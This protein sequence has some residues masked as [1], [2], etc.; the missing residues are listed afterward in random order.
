MATRKKKATTP[1]AKLPPKR[2][3]FVRELQ[4]N[5]GHKTAAYKA[6]GYKAKNDNVA[7]VGANKLVRNGNVAAA[8][9]EFRQETQQRT[10]VTIDWV[11]GKLVE[12]AAK[13]AQATPVLDKEGEP[14]GA[15]NY[16]GAVVNKALELI[17]KHLGAFPIRID[18]KMQHEHV[19]AKIDMTRVLQAMPLE[20]IKRFLDA[21]R[22]AKEINPPPQNG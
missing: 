21:I 16:D 1:K 11:I 15:Y 18:G 19:H 4:K 20:D 13:A 2:E 8:I 7:A 14:T 3:A 12:N 17:G 9:E 5:G 6:A 10:K 22:K